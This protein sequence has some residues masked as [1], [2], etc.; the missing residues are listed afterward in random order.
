[1]N[2]FFTLF[3]CIIWLLID[4]KWWLWHVKII[5]QNILRKKRFL[6]KSVMIIAVKKIAI[7][8]AK[9]TMVAEVNAIIRNVLVLLPATL[10]FRLL[11]G[12]LI[13]IVLISLQENKD[14]TILKPQFLPVSIL[15]GLYQK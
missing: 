4:A 13:P 11:S 5:Q 8:K 1:M 6:L 10:L 9:I 12:A 7:Q 14:F 15:F 3:N 2:N